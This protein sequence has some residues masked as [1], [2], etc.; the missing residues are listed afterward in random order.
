MPE[1][2]EI[3]WGGAEYREFCR[4]RQQYLRAPLGLDLT[5]EDLDAERAHRHFGL[6]EDGTLIGGAVIVPKD[7]DT[8]QLRQMFVVPEHRSRGLGRLIVRHIEAVASESRVGRLFLEARI[9]AVDFYRRC[10]FQ[11]VGEGFVHL[12]I[13]HI[14]MEKSL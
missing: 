2:R 5:D 13:P 8:A 14:R 10:G 3:D 6:F 11:T 12:T 4:L 7:T 9:E 1:L